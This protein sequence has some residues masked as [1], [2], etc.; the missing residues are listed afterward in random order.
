MP[1]VLLGRLDAGAGRLLKLARLLFGVGSRGKLLLRGASP[2]IPPLP[3]P[4]ESHVVRLTI[5][6]MSLWP[7][8]T[9]IGK[10]PHSTSE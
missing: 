6:A 10:N 9:C 8:E 4:C 2:R 5:T 3:V 1:P 7:V